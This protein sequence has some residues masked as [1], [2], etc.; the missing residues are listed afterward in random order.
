MLTKEYKIWTESDRQQL[1]T[2]IQQSKRKCGQVDWDEVTKCM[3]SRSRQQ[4]KSYF[5]NIMKKDCDVK[6]VKYHTWTEQEVNILLTQAEVEHKNWEVIKHNY[7]PNLSSHQIQAKYSYLQL[8]Q[9]KAQIKLINSIPQI[10]MS[11]YN[12]LFD[13]LTNQTLV[14]QLQS[15]L[16]AVSQ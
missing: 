8:Q 7:F 2:A 12:N 14:S 4:C 3:P 9:A 5:M 15:L 13:Y 6:M 16:S 11:Q 1:I 10:Q